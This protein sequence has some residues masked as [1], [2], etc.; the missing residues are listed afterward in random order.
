[1]S[2]V[3]ARFN[4]YSAF[5]LEEEALVLLQLDYRVRRYFRTRDA[6]ERARA[7]DLLDEFGALGLPLLNGPLLSRNLALCDSFCLL[8]PLLKRPIAS[9]LTRFPA[10]GSLPRRAPRSAIAAM[11]GS[12]STSADGSRMSARL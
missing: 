6:L 1:M 11:N 5:G 8:L 4:Q 7:V 3:A 12:W 9:R 2:L 10:H